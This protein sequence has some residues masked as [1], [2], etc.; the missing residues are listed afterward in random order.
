MTTPARRRE[1][2]EASVAFQIALTQIGAKTIEDAMTLW[3]DL[4]PDLQPGTASRWLGRAIRLVMFR[5]KRSQSLA[6]AYYRLAR[7]LR[8]GT[9]IADPYNPEPTYVS[10]NDLRREFAALSG[11]QRPEQTGEEPEPDT[12][13][14]AVEEPV[15]PEPE[16][17][18]P[19][20]TE[21]DEDD[22]DLIL[23][24]EIEELEAELARVEEAAEAEIRE[25]LIEKGPLNSQAKQAE[26]DTSQD[27][28]TVDAERAE[29][30]AQ[31]GRRQAAAAERVA[32]NGARSTIF[33]TGSRDA[34]VIGWVRLSRTGTPCGW[35]AML[36]SRGFTEKSGLYSSRRAAQH[37]GN[38]QDEDKYHDNCKCYAMPVYSREELES[39]PLFELNREYARLWPKVTDGLRGKDAL[40]AWRNYFRR[41]QAAPVQATTAA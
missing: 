40:A 7:A 10:L 31:A 6:L 22:D 21:A 2:D 3:E 19:E 39:S 35:C 9:T 37:R 17:V 28:E 12:E 32:M 20:P 4:P 13:T 1:A 38:N 36:I 30:H 23:V 18:E 34:K 15:E 41:Q 24:E 16:P 11:P 33:A 26:I 25:Q 5:R 14:Q 29:A 27:S 8:T